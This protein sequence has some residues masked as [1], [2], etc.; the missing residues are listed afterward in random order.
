MTP[1]TASHAISAGEEDCK[2]QQTMTLFMLLIVVMIIMAMIMTMLTMQ[3]EH[4]G[5]LK[6]SADSCIGGCWLQYCVD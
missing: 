6:V 2:P 3:H 1:P 5:M 4:E